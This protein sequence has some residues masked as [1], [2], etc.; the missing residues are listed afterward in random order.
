M[1]PRRVKNRRLVSLMA[2]CL[3]KGNADMVSP[4]R[5]SEVEGWLFQLTSRDSGRM[6]T[7]TT[8]EDEGMATL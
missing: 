5:R 6:R 2:R 8:A 4:L 3:I 7:K 1:D